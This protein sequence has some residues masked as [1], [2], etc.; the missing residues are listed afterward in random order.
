M[1]APFQMY[2]A[3]KAAKERAAAIP[4]PVIRT[5]PCD[6]LDETERLVW[7]T[8]AP[9]RRILDVGAGDNRI[10]RKF[11]ALGY[12][13][14]FETVD[15]SPEFDHD[16]RSLAEVAGP[17]DGILALDIIEH[18]TLDEFHPFFERLT[19]LVAG[20]GSLV[21]ST[22]NPACV[23]PMWATDMTHVQQYPLNDLLALLLIAGF[24]CEAYRVLYTRQRLSPVEHVRLLMKKVVTT[25]ILGTDYADGLLV[26]ARAGAGR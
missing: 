17:Y 7:R 11:L 5:Y 26:L 10:K 3:L 6:G 19:A 13:G 23:S 9:C 8:L 18:M 4:R 12:A 16:Y 21:I 2:W 1:G 15:V 20:G 22:P 14:T 25:K 24:E